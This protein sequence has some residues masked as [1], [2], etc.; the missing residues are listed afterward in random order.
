[1][2]LCDWSQPSEGPFSLQ[3]PLHSVATTLRHLKVR[4]HTWTPHMLQAW[5]TALPA[6]QGL[7]Y[8]ELVFVAYDAGAW[9]EPLAP[10]LS[11][12]TTLTRLRLDVVVHD[13]LINTEDVCA[14]SCLAPL[15]RLQTLAI[16]VPM[17]VEG[18]QAMAPAL[19][20]LRALTELDLSRSRLWS[21]LGFL[22]PSLQSLTGLRRLNL[23]GNDLGAHIAQLRLLPY[24][25]ELN[26]NENNL[27]SSGASVAAALLH[28][29][30][31]TQI[32]LSDHF[33]DDD[34][35]HIVGALASLS[36]LQVLWFDVRASCALPQLLTR[37]LQAG[38]LAALKRLELYWGK[39]ADMPELLAA[40]AR[41]IT[42]EELSI[43]MCKVPL[44]VGGEQPQQ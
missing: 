31:L 25:E 26:I 5:A 22:A 6:L 29:P 21:G 38:R 30:G 9:F 35:E 14:L 15:T 36:R 44:P 24:L 33:T 41:L 37:H 17:F 2:Y 13:D 8:L 16:N 3:L 20:Q 40:L 12:L 34:L 19:L 39:C 18:A 32:N 1:M 27:R 4:Y 10:A 28:V 11:Q 42:L 43:N 7:T 23:G